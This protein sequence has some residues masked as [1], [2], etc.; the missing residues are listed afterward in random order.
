MT[1]FTEIKEHLSTYNRDMIL[2]QLAWYSVPEMTISHSDFVVRMHEHKLDQ[3]F[4]PPHPRPAD[5]FRRS[6]NVGRKDQRTEGDFTYKY[7]IHEVGKDSDSIWRHL[8][9][10]IVDYK[11]H[12]LDLQPI[13]ELVFDRNLETILVSC[14]PSIELRPWE[15]ELVSKIQGTYLTLLDQLTA[16]AIRQVII[17][18]LQS[19]SATVVRPS[20]GVYFVAEFYYDDLIHLEELINSIEGCSFHAL[21]L[22][23]DKKQREMLK[24]AFED[25]SIELVDRSL[26]DIRKIFAGDK[27]ISSD[28][29]SVFFDD[30]KVLSARTKEYADLLEESMDTTAARLEVYQDQIFHLMERVK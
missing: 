4:L 22:L 1:D 19:F 8:V 27:H 5:V 17:K 29:Y 30:Y 26:E 24:K 13:V 9:R 6:T 14:L 21:P 2:G 15:D 16:Y 23:D 12:Q 25:E 3:V 20:G 7:S 28:R 11:D 10:E 18:I